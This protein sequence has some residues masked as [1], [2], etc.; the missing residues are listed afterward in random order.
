MTARNFSED[1]AAGA[2]TGST[3]AGGG[4]TPAV[5]NGFG[6][7][8][9]I[10]TNIGS[11]G[12]AAVAAGGWGGGG[13]S[14][15]ASDSGSNSA[16]SASSPPGGGGGW[17]GFSSRRA[18]SS[19]AGYGAD[20]WRSQINQQP[21][22][23]NRPWAGLGQNTGG[24]NRVASSFAEGGAID[25][26]DPNATDPQGSA[27]GNSLQNSINQALASVGNTLSYGR[28]LHGIGGGG[29]Q[30]AMNTD[31]F[32]QSDN[33]EDRRDGSED[34]AGTLGRAAGGEVGAQFARNVSNNSSKIV[35]KVKGM[36]AADPT[37]NKM[38][39][40][41]GI[42]DIGG[43]GSAA[44]PGAQQAIPTDDEEEAQ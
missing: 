22:W 16:P 29:Q 24:F 20:D 39:Q 34:A 10:N 23:E 18:T 43:E 37:K 31:D 30:Q 40:D 36:F 35:D 44:A 21:G 19:P 33:V 7:S 26:G 12:D 3:A 28:K 32:R 9:A 17:G 42:N 13:L 4:L 14:G 6:D 2:M 11:V 5:S 8:G 41:A 25:E 15:G 38:S 27:M 1:G